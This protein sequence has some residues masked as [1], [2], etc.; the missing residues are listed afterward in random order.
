MARILIKGG[1]VWDG[2]QFLHADI[3]TAGDKIIKIGYL[4]NLF[5]I[6]SKLFGY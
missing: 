4:I 6:F 2:E 3:L 5:K 1:R